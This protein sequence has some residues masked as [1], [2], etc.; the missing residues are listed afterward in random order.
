MLSDLNAA[1]RADEAKDPKGK[2]KFEASYKTMGALFKGM[3]ILARKTISDE[4]V[5]L[6][7]KLDS[8]PYQNK[9]T[10]PGIAIQPMLKVGDEWKLGGN[11][12]QHSVKWD[13]NGSI[14]TYN[15]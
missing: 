11:T 7:V 3:Q 15:P 1:D 12:H 9:P 5:E 8:D 2:E 14:Q 10:G 13:Q 4:R 6:K